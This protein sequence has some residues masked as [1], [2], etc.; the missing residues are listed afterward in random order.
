MGDLSAEA[1]WKE[2]DLNVERLFRIRG[3]EEYEF[4]D[5]KIE[6]ISA[7]HTESK[8]GN[9]RDRFTAFRRTEA[10]EKLCGMVPWKCTTSHYR[11]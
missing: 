11:C 9:Y 6:V 5:V 3:R 4:D 2:Y 7:R 10:E 1:L 8:G